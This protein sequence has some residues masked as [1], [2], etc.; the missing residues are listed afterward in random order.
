M[1][2]FHALCFCIA[3]TLFFLFSESASRSHPTNEDLFVGTPAFATS[4]SAFS[5]WRVSVA[6]TPR[7]KTCPRGSAT[8][9]AGKFAALQ[10]VRGLVTDH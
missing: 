8:W 3:Q 4:E 2:R 1:K 10:G 9:Q 6:S 5:V 7:T